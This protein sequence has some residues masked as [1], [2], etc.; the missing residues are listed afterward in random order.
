MVPVTVVGKVIGSFVMLSGIGIFVLWTSLF[1]SSFSE[2]IKRRGFVANW[3]MLAE[4][5]VFSSLNIVQLGEVV[6]MMQ[7]LVV[8]ARHMVER[9][10]EENHAMFLIVDGMVEVELYPNPVLLKAGDH[11]GEMSLIEKLPAQATIVALEETKML[12]LDK[13]SFHDM[14]S[15]HENLKKALHD[16]A[17]SRRHWLKNHQSNIQNS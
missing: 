3:Q 1:A 4:V 14:M 15:K 6:N 8:P 10:G 5:P 9:I 13:D 17:I 11:F 16:V 7:P 2:E 12:V